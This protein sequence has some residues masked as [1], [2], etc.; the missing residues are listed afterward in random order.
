MSNRISRIP[1]FGLVALALV[2]SVRANDIYHS[3]SDSFSES[4]FE[5]F[6]A[7]PQWLL[8]ALPGSVSDRAAHARAA[9]SSY[10]RDGDRNEPLYRYSSDVGALATPFNLTLFNNVSLFPGRGDSFSKVFTPKVSD[11]A[12][13]YTYSRTTSNTAGTADPWSAGTNWNAVP[14]SASDTTLTFGNG[15]PLAAGATIFTNNDIAGDFKINILNFNSGGPASGTA[16]TVTVSGNRLE[17]IS[18]G[19]TTPTMSINAS[20]TVKPILA[21][22]NDLLL[23]NNL[24][25]SN[26]SSAVLS[27]TI[28]GGGSLAKTSGSGTLTLSGQNTFS[29]GFIWGNPGSQSAAGILSL[30]GSSVGSP[31]SITSGPLGT[32]TFTVRNSGSATTNFIQSSDSTTR[33]IANAITFGGTSILF[34]TGGT[35]DLVFNGAVDLGT[36]GRTFSIGNPLTTFGGVISNSANLTKAGTGTMILSGS[37]TYSGTTQVNAGTL[38]AT[39][40]STASNTSSAT[41]TGNVTVGGTGTILAGGSTSGSTGTI[42][43]SVDYTGSTNGHLSPG[44][45]GD[46]TTTTAI[47]HTGALTL[48][49]SSI[50]NVNLNNTTAGTGYDQ[51]VA[52]S[53]INLN[54][55][56][57][58][59]AIGGTLNLGDKFFIMENG[60]NSANGLSLFS[61]GATV[62]S[63]AYTFAINYADN[64]D[65]GLIAN[66]ISLTVT[67]IPEPG[68]WVGASLALAAIAW[69]QRK[70]LSH[71]LQRA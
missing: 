49:S 15:V 56:T 53:T 30:G 46:G 54:S 9:R 19:A 58:T 61:N 21:I 18:N 44:I 45:A 43:G 8:N 38:L 65:G 29:G 28:S 31:G 48:S 7:R 71:L 17:F 16:P 24:A 26:T 27:G 32:G 33:T 55:A 62:T 2:P 60:S 47:L 51:L 20:G 6:Y 59:L 66:D 42:V 39:G 4:G 41:G 11:V 63:G 1:L 68:T 36:G 12:T 34:T 57:L 3:G 13:T 23:T 64:G 14:V 35:G 67:A 40:G 70:R 69:T 50:F 22:S 10:D 37:S 52:S 5:L 25:V